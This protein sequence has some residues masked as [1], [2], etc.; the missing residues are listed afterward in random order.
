MESLLKNPL[1]FNFCRNV[2]DLNNPHEI[3]FK[4]TEILKL[5]AMIVWYRAVLHK[6]SILTVETLD[7]MLKYFY[8]IISLKITQK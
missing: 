7:S 2:I 4:V 1:I 8:E 6:H 5:K 3:I